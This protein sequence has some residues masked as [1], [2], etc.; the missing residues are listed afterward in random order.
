MYDP[1]IRDVFS[2]LLRANIAL[3]YELCLLDEPL[4]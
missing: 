1:G 4:I 3:R 2:A